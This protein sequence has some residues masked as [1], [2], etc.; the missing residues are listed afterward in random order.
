MRVLQDR[1]KGEKC[2]RATM[3]VP[4]F[5]FQ[6]RQLTDCT[7][8]KNHQKIIMKGIVIQQSGPEVFIK[9][10]SKKRGRGGGR[11]EARGERQENKEW[12]RESKR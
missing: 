4:T 8:Q 3:T 11:R 9:H 12:N 5:Y 7:P 1:G 6:F 10:Q 2:E